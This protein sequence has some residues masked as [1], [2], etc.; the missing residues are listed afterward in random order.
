[1]EPLPPT[2][3]LQTLDK[4]LYTTNQSSGNPSAPLY[5]DTRQDNSPGIFIDPRNLG[6][7]LRFDGVTISAQKTFVSVN[8][9]EMPTIDTDSGDIFS[10]VNIA[11][12]I[13]S[14]TT[15]LSG[16][17]KAGDYLML[18]LTDDGTARALTWGAMF[19]STT[20]TLPTT[21]VISTLLRVGFQYDTVAGVWQCIAIA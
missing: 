20:V 4:T 13:T 2:Q 17:P 8:Q 7:G 5:P 18:Q 14:F 11:Q 9:T 15:N 12:D 10:L 21:T 3:P 1:M 6:R 19:A 16:S